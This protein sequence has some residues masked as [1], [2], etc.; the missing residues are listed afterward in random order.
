MSVITV[1]LWHHNHSEIPAAGLTTPFLNT[2]SISLWIEQIETLIW[3]VNVMSVSV[4]VSVRLKSRGSRV[5]PLRWLLRCLMS[6]CVLWKRSGQ[7]SP[8]WDFVIEQG[9][10]TD[11]F[12][13]LALRQGRILLSC[14]CVLCV[15]KRLFPLRMLFQFLECSHLQYLQGL[16]NGF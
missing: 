11:C 13:G 10:D 16:A 4:N 9:E 2:D 12:A 1:K 14:V 7:G 15:N 5:N 6:I 8:S 3:S